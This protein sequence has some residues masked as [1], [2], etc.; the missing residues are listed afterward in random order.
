MRVP[1]RAI[2]SYVPD[3]KSLSSVLSWQE[4]ARLA[5]VLYWMTAHSGEAE[6]DANVT[7]FLTTPDH[8]YVLGQNFL[9]DS[10][11]FWGQ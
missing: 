11:S 9:G 2:W 8:S 5:T 6:T 1:R 7:Q 4:G 10:S 3:S